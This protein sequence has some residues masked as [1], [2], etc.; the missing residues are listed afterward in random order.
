[1]RTLLPVIVVA[2]LCLTYAARGA[3]LSAEERA[4]FDK[5]QSDIVK[6][7]PS[8]MDEPALKKV[9]RARFY[10]AKVIINQGGGGSE[11]VEVKVARV[12]QD[13][14]NVSLP[15]TDA[16][17]P[18]LKQMLSPDFK[19]RN[20][21]DAKTLEAA[22]DVLYPVSA[23]GGDDDKKAKAIKHS[24]NQWLFI[25]GAFFAK[26][27]GFAFTTDTGGA[28]TAVEYSLDLP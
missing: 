27:K 16:K 10:N 23:F 5:H 24:G 7:E 20:N 19:L 21:Q 8:P 6:V 2:L 11:T 17:M 18:K 25:R 14:E 26:H 15:S 3:E 12:G 13:L 1:M 4:F 22:L 28:V 9:F